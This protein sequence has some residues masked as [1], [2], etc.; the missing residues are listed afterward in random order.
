MPLEAW[1]LARAA[2]ILLSARQGGG[3]VQGPKPGIADPWQEP[4]TA[5]SYRDQPHCLRG[6]EEDWST[7]GLTFQ[8]QEWI[9]LFCAGLGLG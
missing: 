9:I 8:L 6:A 3:F 5:W 2:E 4:G 7:E 1:S